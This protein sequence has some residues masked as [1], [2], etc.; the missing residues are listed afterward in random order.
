RVLVIAEVVVVVD[1]ARG[2][3]DGVAALLHTRGIAHHIR[4]RCALD[5][6]RRGALDNDVLAGLQREAVAAAGIGR[7]RHAVGLLT[8]LQNAVAVVVLIGVDRPSGEAAFVVGSCGRIIIKAVRIAN[9]VGVAIQELHA[10]LRRVLVIAEVVVVVD[11]ARG[12]SDGVAAL[13]HTRG[14]AHH[15]RKRCAL[16]PTRR[17][18]LDNDVLAGLQR[19]AVAAAGIGRRRH[20]VGLLTGLQNAVA[21]VVLIGVDRPSGEAAFVVGSCGRIIVKAVRIANAVGVA[22]QELHARL[23]RVLVIAEVVVVVDL[24][25][26]QSDGVAALLHTRAIAHHV[27]GRP[28]LDPTRRGALDNDVH[29]GLQREAVAAAGI[30]RRRHAV[31]LLTGLQNAVAV[32]VLIGVDRPSGEAAFVVGSCGR[33]IVKAVRIANAVGVAIQEL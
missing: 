29:A 6:T 18:A 27:A 13:L 20:A 22:I 24:T 10:R 17:G 33:I 7:R 26:G 2:Q 12:Q 8:G 30:G 1:L 28:A 21:V 25:G 11:L 23:R 5:P 4:K 9:A 3:S 14:I 19:E 31:G 32:V 16:D 15:I